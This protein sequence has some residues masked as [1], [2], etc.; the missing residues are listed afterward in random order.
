MSNPSILPQPDVAALEAE[1]NAL[2][3]EGRAMDL[4]HT[5]ARIAAFRAI[6]KRSAGERAELAVLQARRRLL[7][8]ALGRRRG[9]GAGRPREQR[10]LITAL[11]DAR[12]TLADPPATRPVARGI[13]RSLVDN[14]D[15]LLARLAPLIAIAT[16]LPSET[17]VETP[18]AVVGP[19]TFTVGQLWALA[20]LLAE[21]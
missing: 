7:I 19:H 5:D 15:D 1:I 2:T 6:A 3:S 16:S 8:A 4:S 13:V 10:S 20:Q 12:A 11:E 14:I 9:P 18:L 17:P 21:D